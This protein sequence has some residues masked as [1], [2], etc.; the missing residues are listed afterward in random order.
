[1]STNMIGSIVLGGA[2]LCLCALLG[3][4]L[5]VL[6]YARSD[7]YRRQQRLRQLRR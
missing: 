4:G 3:Q 7:R 5:C 2:A 6:L 1:M